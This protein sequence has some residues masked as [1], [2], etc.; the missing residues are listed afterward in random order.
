MHS[1][2]PSE[3]SSCSYTFV[4]GGTQPLCRTQSARLDARLN[5][6]V[7]YV[8][9]NGEG[10]LVFFRIVCTV[11]QIF[12]ET[13]CHARW[14]RSYTRPSTTSSCPSTSS[15]LCCQEM[16]SISTYSKDDNK[17]VASVGHSH[18]LSLLLGFTQG[19][20]ADF[21]RVFTRARLLYSPLLLSIQAMSFNSSRLSKFYAVRQFRWHPSSWLHFSHICT[22]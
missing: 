21:L 20:S 10:R 22:R 17:L 8:Y 18:A 4:R 1:G 16:G 7:C 3:Q 13:K 12:L 6:G 2:F 15:T 5:Q 14:V 19:R 11:W 9:Y